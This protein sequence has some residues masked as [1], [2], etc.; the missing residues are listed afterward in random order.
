MSSLTL[1][2]LLL[3]EEGGWVAQCLEYD[4]AA[5]GASV[6]EAQINFR[7]TL[8]GQLELD[9]QR[10]REP[11]A[12]KKPA[13]PWY[14]QTLQRSKRLAD[15]ISLKSPKKA[16]ATPGFRLTSAEAWVQLA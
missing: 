2:V 1:R 14:W 4:I 6:E 7:D 10:G 5:R 11:F 16:P 12:G 15:P 13:P 3:K 8:L 9:R